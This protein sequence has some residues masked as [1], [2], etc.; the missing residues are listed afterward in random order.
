M[1]LTFT[2]GE[3]APADRLDALQDLVNR[4]FLPISITPHD[5]A[6][7]GAPGGRNGF[8]GTVSGS[9]LGGVRV[10]RVRATSMSAVR[11]RRHVESAGIDDYLLAL[12]VTGTAHGSQDGREVTLGPGDFTLFDSSHPYSITFLGGRLFEHVIFQVPRASLGAHREIAGTIARLVPAAS[13]AGQLIAP[14]L[15]TLARPWRSTGSEA[16]VQSFVDAG[17]DLAVSAA[18]ICSGLDD[19]AS[20][21]GRA[22]TGQLRRYVLA[23]LS[24]PELSP[25]AAAQASYIS[26]RQ[27]HR[28]F[29]R[30]GVSFGAWVRE[31]RL[32]RCRDDL[33]NPQLSDLTI[34]EIASRWG[35]GSASHFTRAFAARYGTTPR[36]LRRA[37][38]TG[39][40][41]RAADRS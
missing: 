16:P 23:H 5:T 39:T 25:D 37:A 4:V 9:E 31:E 34:A 21:R 38:Y 24:E 40:P 15:L 17:L 8:E 12:Q 1:D 3:I 26:V 27:L 20:P 14:Y 32:R 18:R 6:E 11:A 30:D 28:H 35:F 41:L 13:S 10:W 29:A 22:L 7:A 33:T 2:T 19:H 36:Q